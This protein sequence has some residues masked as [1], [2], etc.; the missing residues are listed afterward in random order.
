M[1]Y[2]DLPE[3]GWV[4]W[5]VGTGDSITIVVDAENVMQIDLRDMK[6]AEEDDAVVAPIIDR[7][8][9][10]LP[11]TS[12]DLPRLAVFVVSHHDRDHCAGAKRFFEEVLVEELWVTPRMW[13]EKDAGLEF[14]EHAE[15]LFAEAER[16]IVATLAAAACGDEPEAGDRIRITG[17]HP[18]AARHSYAALPAWHRYGVDT[19]V[20]VGEPTIG[21][22]EVVVHGPTAEDCAVLG[23]AGRNSSS[24]LLRMRLLDGAGGDAALLLVGDADHAV[25]ERMFTDA[26]AAG[27]LDTL[28]WDIALTAHHCSRHAVFGPDAEG[29]E[30]RKQTVLDALE[31]SARPGAR[32]VASSRP[33]RPRDTVGDDPPHRL[34]RDAYE[35]DVV[36]NDV[37]CTAEHPTVEDPR[38][39][40]FSLQPGVGLTLLDP[41][42]LAETVAQLAYASET[43][44]DSLSGNA[45]APRRLSLL[46]T[47]GAT[48]SVEPSQRTTPSPHHPQDPSAGPAGG[49]DADRDAVHDAVARARGRSAGP[50]TS[51]GFG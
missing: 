45:A 37:L 15:A 5:P 24:M 51:I 27:R 7:L 50:P 3:Q 46:A 34:A 43:K 28:A 16:R 22:A 2:T 30:E 44:T 48:S 18:E 40:V 25:L 9:E 32:M 8:V 10:T 36:T 23:E 19:V 39:V 35:E 13:H 6:A 31:A 41:E 17:E 26:A 1:T 11:R 49:G 47:L 12:D 29:C 38:P 33:F 14:N 20:T 4:F 42:E 21:R